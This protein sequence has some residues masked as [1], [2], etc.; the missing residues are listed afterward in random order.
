[1]SLATNSN[2]KSSS[3]YL[4]IFL[5]IAIMLDCLLAY[6]FIKVRYFR[7]ESDFTFGRKELFN[8]LSIQRNSIVFLG[9]SLTEQFELGE[10]FKNTNICN[11]GINGDDTPKMLNRLTVITQAHPEK[12]FLEAGINDIAEGTK[13]ET[14]LVN[15]KKLIHT[16]HQECTTSKLY[17]QS[18][19]PV[20]DTGGLVINAK[21][22]NAD[23]QYVNNSIQLY[24]SS[25]G[26]PFINTHD[27]FTVNGK[28]NPKY[29]INDDGVHLS[30]E[31]YL[32]W[33][34]IL[35]PYVKE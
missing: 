15:Y 2:G 6:K 35:Q 20:N 11:R 29:C 9:T 12:I 3:Q 14:V 24:C 5:F 32:L 23:I 22:K 27:Q 18:I 1:M 25:N 26:I 16:L 30:G 21:I 28:M 7:H 4:K 8:H 31:G 17:V 10:L 13:I 33:T 19:L 34:K